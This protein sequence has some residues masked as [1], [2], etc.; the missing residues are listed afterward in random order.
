M[1]T[2]LIE[3]IGK[4]VRINPIAGGKKFRVLASK[5]MD[6]IK[7]DDS[8]A[9]NGV[10]LTATCVEPDGFWADA[11]GET[12]NKTTL[13]EMHEG[14]AVNVERAMKLSDRLGGHIVQGHVNGIANV[15]Q[16]KKLGENYFLEINIPAE[17]QKYTIAEGSIS[18]DGISLTIAKL[19]STR[20]GL[21]VIPHTWAATNLKD[22][23]VGD[24]VNI[25]TDVLAKYI[26]KLLMNNKETGTGKF[27][28]EW[29]KNL[30]Y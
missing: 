22:R 10:C 23:K 18:I 20:V 26:E 27:S 8:I 25:E 19:N 5:I 1:F 4:I 14:A 6:D 2:G 16:I 15:T 13:A 9:I 12:L 21:S 30:G 28:D 29:F 11:V 17:L 7:V 3:E 24:R